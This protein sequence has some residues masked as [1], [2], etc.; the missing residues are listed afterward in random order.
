MN[1][2]TLKK[3]LFEW[4]IDIIRSKTDIVYT[5][6]KE[7]IPNLLNV[8]ERKVNHSKLFCHDVVTE[9][10][11]EDNSEQ[12]LKDNLV[13]YDGFDIEVS[14]VHSVKGQ[15]HTA[16]LYLETSYQN[17]NETYET[18][19][20][21]TQLKHNSFSDNRKYHKQS[22]KMAYV[23][24]SRPTDL[25]CVAVSKERFNSHLSDIDMDKWEI[26]QI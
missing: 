1:I 23:G 14:T 2:P 4:S 13:N 9:P 12:F 8:F 6:I 24:F 15:T 19:R 3:K 22:T 26:I 7:Y 25:L 17:G 10:I 20:L 5:L 11:K 21:S 16:T 18:Q